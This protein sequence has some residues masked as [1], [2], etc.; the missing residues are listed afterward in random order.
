MAEDDCLCPSCR[1]WVEANTTII[2]DPVEIILNRHQGVKLGDYKVMCLC[3]EGV[4]AGPGFHRRHVAGLIYKA[5][6]IDGQEGG[7]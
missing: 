7:E 6:H 4:F 2:T 1:A 3:G 5:L